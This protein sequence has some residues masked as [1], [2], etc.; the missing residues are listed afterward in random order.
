[1]PFPIR[2]RVRPFRLHKIG[3]AV[4]SLLLLCDARAVGLGNMTVSS[5]LGQ[6]LQAEIELLSTGAQDEG[7]LLARIAGPDAFRQAG[8]DFHPLLPSLRFA[9]VA[10]GDRRV[11]RVTSAQPVNEPFVDMLLE[12]RS[13]DGRLM[14]EYVFLLDPPA[15][16]VQAGSSSSVPNAGT[17]S[18]TPAVPAGLGAAEKRL[19]GEQPPSRKATA[20]SPAAKKPA[21]AAQA[22]KPRLSLTDLS[23]AP[24]TSP[25]FAADDNAAMEKAVSEA[26]DRVKA[27]E[28]KVETLQKLLT[29]TNSLLTEMQKRNELL[30]QTDADGTRSVAGAAASMTSSV[31]PSVAPSMT[32]SAASSAA[33]EKPTGA[34]LKVTTT[35]AQ[36]HPAPGPAPAF[37]SSLPGDILL[38]SIAGLGVLGLGGLAAWILRRRR[39]G[40]RRTEPATA[41][42]ELATD[43]LPTLTDAGNSMF[44]PAFATT[45]SMQISADDPVAEADIYIAYGRDKQAE[46]ILKDALRVRPE[47]PAIHLKL[48]SI[49]ASREERDSFQAQA[50]ELHARTHGEG[51]E[52]RQA[53]AMGLALD[54]GNPLYAAGAG[55]TEIIDDHV[56]EFTSAQDD[57]A[58]ADPAPAMDLD[59]AA[60]LQNGATEAPAAADIPARQ[61][62]AEERPAP[63]IGPIDFDLE[64]PSLEVSEV[65]H[66]PA[67][68]ASAPAPGIGPIDFDLGLPELPV[69]AA[70]SEDA[71]AAAEAGVASTTGSGHAADDGI[72]TLNLDDFL[73]ELAL[74]ND[75]KNQ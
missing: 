55:E 60:T 65:P 58:P 54:P 22:G 39:A 51:E 44:V 73:A 5:A 9:I 6:P 35:L 62:V 64:L 46:D 25:V 19:G 70:P 52:W 26:N 49:Y 56:L 31:A 43:G 72:A 75:K 37:S 18:Y 32:S 50:T 28:Q 12:L 63:G 13:A 30:K 38:P 3:V 20:V 17:A 71:P 68:A 40:A 14:R 10:R 67:A 59:F 41:S 33:P 21:A 74:A 48:L 11:I 57:A 42:A 61:A 7:A 34:P 45:T 15:D 16:G 36:P 1:M 66:V 2:S 53:A 24:G 69:I 29:A 27:L 47:N 4:A 23:V 8:I